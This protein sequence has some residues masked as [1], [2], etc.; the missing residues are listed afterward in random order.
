VR[1]CRLILVVTECRTGKVRR[2][3]PPRFQERQR[4]KCRLA[5]LI[6]QWVWCTALHIKGGSRPGRWARLVGDRH[7]TRNRTRHPGTK[8]PEG[9]RDFGDPSPSA[10]EMVTPACGNDRL[11]SF[12]CVSCGKWR[13]PGQGCTAVCRVFLCSGSGAAVWLPS[14]WPHAGAVACRVRVPRP[15]AAASVWFGWRREVR[16]IIPSVLGL[17]YSGASRGSTNLVLN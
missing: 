1:L 7:H 5:K 3:R 11:L 10:A 4:R 13:R 17:D 15:P 16:V 14:G 9:Q 12:Y 6:R 8:S 2:E